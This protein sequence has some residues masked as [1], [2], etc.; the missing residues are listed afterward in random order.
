[1]ETTA[2]PGQTAAVQVCPKAP[3]AQA[4]LGEVSGDVTGIRLSYVKPTYGVGRQHELGFDEGS[5]VLQ[6]RY[7]VGWKAK[8]VP[9]I[10]IGAVQFYKDWTSQ[11]EFSAGIKPQRY[12]NEA[13]AR[14]AGKRIE[15][16]DDPSGALNPVT[17]R[18]ARL[19]P[20]AAPAFDVKILLRKPAEVK[21]EKGNAVYADAEF[22]LRIGEHF[23]CPSLITFEKMSYAPFLQ[24]LQQSRVMAAQEQKVPL[25]KAQL[26]RWVYALGTKVL[27][28]KPGRKSTLI[29]EITRMQDPVTKRGA[30]LS[31]AEVTELEDLM[32]A[33]LNAQAEHPEVIADD[34]NP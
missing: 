18:V 1:M 28:S 30:V 11:A 19:G 3:V 33:L 17:G 22:Y 13:A 8:P 20:Q 14:A 4:S 9:I 34:A 23:Y 24:L 32:G 10:V 25:N 5:I 31:E 12:P 7:A 29:P 26:H 16:I 21:D 15:W 2:I 27:P 6:E